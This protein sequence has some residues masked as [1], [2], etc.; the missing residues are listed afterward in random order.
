MRFGLPVS[1][2]AASTFSK[3]LSLFDI[4]LLPSAL[5]ANRFR[6]VSWPDRLAKGFVSFDQIQDKDAVLAGQNALNLGGGITKS[7]S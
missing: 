1:V 6:V 2:L 3:K 4:T 5:R 7:S